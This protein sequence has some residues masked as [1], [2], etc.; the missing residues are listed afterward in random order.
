MLF[1][2]ALSCAYVSALIFLLLPLPGSDADLLLRGKAPSEKGA[3]LRLQGTYPFL[4]YTLLGLLLASIPVVL[5]GTV[6]T[7]SGL[8]TMFPVFLIGG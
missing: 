6:Y 4:I 1:T 2:G 3:A 5:N 7:L 8:M